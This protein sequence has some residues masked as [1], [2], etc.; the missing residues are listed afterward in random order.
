MKRYIVV[1]IAALVALGFAAPSIDINFMRP[2]IERAIQRGLG[3]R[4]VEVSGVYLNLLTGPGFTVEGV[5]IYEDPRAGIE[6]FIFVG[7]LEARVRLLPLLSRRLEFS[8]LR[9]HEGPNGEKPT[10][11]L[12][13]TDAGPWNFQLLLGAISGS[14]PSIKMH[15]GRVNFK[16]GDTKSVFYFDDA[17]LEV[18]PYEDGSVELRFSGAPSR[19]DQAA[20]NFG[21]FFVRGKWDGSKL[22]MRVELEP[23]ALEEVARLFDQGGFGLHGI[24]ALDAQL[25]GP[26]SKLDVAGTLRVDDVHRWDLLPKRGGGWSVAYNGSLD[27][28]GERLELASAQGSPAPLGLQFRAWDFLSTPHWE[29]AADMNKIP[30]ATLVEVA[31]HMGAPV[32]EKLAAEGSVSG[33]VRY[34]EERGLEG[35]IRLQDTS[36]KLPDV[37]PVRAAD[38][39]VAISA[40]T[41]SLDPASVEI[42]ENETAQIEGSYELGAGLDL[43]I[44]TRSLN[45]ADLRSFG[46]AAIPLLEQT[47][48][49]NW[50][51]WARYQWSPGGKG[52]WTGEYDLQNARIAIDGLA[53]PLRIQS[54]SVSCAGER[55]SVTRMRARLGEL[56]FTGEYRWEPNAIRPHRF[57]ISIP[58]A[59]ASEI[60]HLLAPSLERERGFLARTLRLGSPAVPAWLAARRADGTVSIDALEIGDTRA[61]LDPARVLWD[62]TQIRVAHL[63][64]HADPA[65]IS[66]DLLID[67]SNRVPHYRFD[68]KARD[69]AYK[70]GRLDLDGSI[71]S[72]GAGADLLA[73][74]HGEGSLKGRSI[75]FTP[76]A[77][78]RSISGC[79]EI[80]PALRIKLSCLEISQGVDTLTGA[81]A[82]QSDGRLVLDLANHGRAV[83]YMTSAASAVSQP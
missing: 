44:T 33:S 51:G 27:L 20:Q 63:N 38:A 43:K 39:Q 23:S 1:A 56:A 7:E 8:S 32:S 64:A 68:G 62:G 16:F 80:A 78:F 45:V 6:P 53:A 15:T 10:I 73:A 4:R 76:D 2:R 58:R 65:V 71:E 35:R 12:V 75:A 79:F 66:G 9:L 25:S 26:P 29:A 57:K 40:K 48:Q 42:G 21:H 81:G 24:V 55:V 54:A 19:T 11:N 60:E 22:D 36:L 77:E 14:M 30:A 34:S 3:G 52:E 49:G 47:P 18:S 61:R 37:Q 46:L 69:V 59:D 17:D 82:T 70:G 13:K 28:R 74:A 41:F 72:D 5:T 67:L 50:R 83:R 31:R